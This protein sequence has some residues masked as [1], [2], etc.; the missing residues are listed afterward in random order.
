MTNA[1]NPA[2]QDSD[3]IQTLDLTA[4]VHLKVSVWSGQAKL[5]PSDIR[6]GDGGK[7]P[8][9]EV[10]QIGNKKICDPKLLKV[11]TT[12]RERIRNTVT[13]YG[14]SLMGGYAVPVDAVP[15]IV[16][17]LDKL[18]AEF[19]EAKEKFMASYDE[20]VENW[21]QEHPEFA[22]AIRNSVLSAEQAGERISATYSIYQLSPI[23]GSEELL[24]GT[25]QSM[26]NALIEDIQREARKF[27]DKYGRDSIAKVDPRTS[28]TW[29]NLRFKVSGLTY[30][31]AKFDALHDLLQETIDLY[32]A[33][34]GSVTGINLAT[35]KHNALVLS[36]DEI[37]R[38]LSG[39]SS[40]DASVD[41]APSD[42]SPADADNG[43][44]D[45]VE[46]TDTAPEPDQPTTEGAVAE[47][48]S[49]SNPDTDSAKESAAPEEG[50]QPAQDSDFDA[51]FGD[52]DDFLTENMEGEGDSAS[53]EAPTQ[54]D[55]AQQGHSAERVVTTMDWGAW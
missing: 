41:S 31:D 37:H 44:S 29:K 54:E 15:K 24:D 28:A 42:D 7:L 48:V 46:S 14:V 16:P 40:A 12:L 51:L 17:V 30:L 20:A 53:E 52:L 27:Y 49:A 36:T 2:A 19:D 35:L 5:D 33:G 26:S 10:A 21:I 55:T 34:S 43:Q 6:L 13:D 18:I 23:K 3:L 39:D 47:E 45:A 8:P 38:V 4:L 50:G 25:D 1:Q 32:A 9:A 22:T 11:F